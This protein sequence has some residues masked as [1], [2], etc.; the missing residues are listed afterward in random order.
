MD[1][2]FISTASPVKGGRFDPGSYDN[3]LVKAVAPPAVAALAVLFRLSSCGFLLEGFH[4]WIHEVGHASVAWLSSRPAVPLP[5]GWTNIEANKSLPLYLFILVALV[6]LAVTGWR[7]RRLWPIVLGIALIAAQS[8]MTWSLSEERAHLWMIFGGVGGEFYLSAA[9]MGLFFF[10]FPE[11]FKWGVCRY[12]VL[13]IG[14]ASFFE[15]YAFW[16]QVKR[17][18]QG[19]PFGSMING[20]D[21]GGGDMNIL[22]EEFHW[23]RHQIV[24]TYNHLGDAC[25]VSVIGVYLFFN[26]R[27]DRVFY[28]LLSRFFSL[29]LVRQEKRSKD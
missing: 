24:F 22:T 10:E 11:R 23:T 9:M 5:F 27:L 15:S 7:E 29:G 26:L 12:V 2:E 16:K 20:E 14:A 19:I 28:P 6:V 21:D 17:G 4:V 1:P 13:F 3:A 8:L 25:L 18:A